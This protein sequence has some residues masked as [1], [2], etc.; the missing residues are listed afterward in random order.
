MAALSVLSALLMILL[1]WRE[2]RRPRLWMWL[3][4]AVF[5]LLVA[6]ALL[7]PSHTAVDGGKGG[8]TSRPEW[9][10]WLPT[11]IDPQLTLTA[12]MPWGSAVVL[13]V[14]LRCA[15]L[16]RRA[17]NLLWALLLISGVLLALVGIYFR[18]TESRLI[19]GL[20]P[21]LAGYH[22]A[23]F[24][25]RN[26]WGAYAT[27]LVALGLGFAFSQLRAWREG[28][29]R[30][31]TVLF[32]ALAALLVAMTVPLTGSRSGII[33]VT[34]MLVLGL[35]FFTWRML[36]LRPTPRQRGARRAALAAVLMLIVGLGLGVGLASAKLEWA[37]EKTERQWAAQQFGGEFDL[38]WHYTKDTVRM[39]SDR[40]VW[41]WGLGTFEPV[42]P[43]YQG[44][45]LRREDGS[46]YVVVNAAHNDWAQLWAE[47]GAV[48]WLVLVLPAGALLGRGL[49][50]AGS[51]RR[52][53]A[54]GCG[55]VLLGALAEL[56]F[57]NPAVLLLWTTM[58]ATA[59][60]PARRGGVD[61]QLQ[62]RQI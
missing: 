11:T 50:S 56:P 58:I 41:G 21:D 51:G 15:Q 14:G 27:L 24:P 37:W 49:F 13:G 5:F 9:I 53:V 40:P 36:R 17:V 54:L 25:Y 42:F 34:T 19:L 39:A 33:L 28:R 20:K 23:S 38:R 2:G 12:L 47:V 26:H 16:G 48:G 57:L 3:P 31:Q 43:L 30:L 59:A 1:A 52:W 55:V 22:F 61:E 4:A 60:P 62:S 46:I 7:N 10:A 44:D 29:A 45:Y 8:W 6:V 35:G 18:V 32:G